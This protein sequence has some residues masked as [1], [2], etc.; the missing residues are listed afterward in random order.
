MLT[1]GLPNFN[2]LLHPVFDDSES[3]C[4]VFFFFPK[5]V[6]DNSAVEVEEPEEEVEEPEEEV[7]E[8]EE[9]ESE[10]EESDSE[11]EESEEEE[12]DS[13]EEEVEFSVEPNSPTVPDLASTNN[14]LPP[15]FTIGLVQ[16]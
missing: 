14:T 5:D 12:S 1:V 4:L 10:E 7:V 15:K 3:K 13:E 6:L 16:L 8:P 2:F 11:E 9:E